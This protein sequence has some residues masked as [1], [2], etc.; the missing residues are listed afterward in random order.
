MESAEDAQVSLQRE[1]LPEAKLTPDPKRK[2]SHFARW[3]KVL[4]AA[5]I[6][7]CLA[8]GLFAY[9]HAHQNTPAQQATWCDPTG[10]GHPAGLESTNLVAISSTDIW[11]FGDI[12]QAAEGSNSHTAILLAPRFEHWDGTRW[13]IIPGADTNQLFSELQS[14]FTGQ[15]LNVVS[16]QSL[17]VISPDDMWA[18][19]GISVSS[20]PTGQSLG[21]AFIEHWNGSSW[22]VIDTPES[23]DS[24][25]NS[26]V[27]ISANDIWAVGSAGSSPLV[28]HWN[29]TQWGSIQLPSTLQVARLNGVAATSDHD[30]W[31]VGQTPDHTP[32]AIHWD[33]QSWSATS[34]PATLNSGDFSFVQEI[35]PHD[36]WVIGPELLPS[37]SS[38][39]PT[40]AHWD[41]Q[42]WSRI[43]NINGITV[44]SAFSGIAAHGPND[45]WVV[46]STTDSKHVTRPLIEHWDGQHWQS[47]SL[48]GISYGGID[49]VSITGGKVWIIGDQTD[50][51]GAVASDKGFIET[52]C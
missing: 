23:K 31:A 9:T 13:S 27:A 10:Y 20:N 3:F 1:M 40:L 5:L 44:G 22:Q 36:I 30:I 45:V 47:V 11:A 50:A 12:T 6:V 17:A 42:Q 29:G 7:I 46:G 21:H 35:S 4:V 52:M 37:Q 14:K 51:T 24:S 15:T 41:G 19:G 28:E 33:G 34:L 25:L 32:I 39:Q 8:G 16:L 18:V 43:E 2:Q 38:P 48:P 26:L 49:G